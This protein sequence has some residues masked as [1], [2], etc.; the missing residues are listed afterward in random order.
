[1]TSYDQSSDPTEGINGAL[2]EIPFECGLL[3]AVGLCLGPLPLGWDTARGNFLG[4][5]ALTCFEIMLDQGLAFCHEKT[6]SVDDRKGVDVVYL[7]F[8]KAF[9]TLSNSLKRFGS[10]VEIQIVTS[11]KWCS[12]GADIEVMLFHIFSNDLD[13]RIESTLGNFMDDTK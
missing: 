10:T 11:Y 1:M 3:G 7:D 6:A 8:S 9:P 5:S 2:L 13:E 4:L 12:S